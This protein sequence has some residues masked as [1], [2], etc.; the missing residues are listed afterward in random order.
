[1]WFL[2][3][4]RAR[5]LRVR[6]LKGLPPTVPVRF[7]MG[8]LRAGGGDSNVPTHIRSSLLRTTPRLRTSRRIYRVEY[9]YATIRRRRKGIT[10]FRIHLLTDLSTRYSTSSDAF[11]RTELRT[12][13]S[14]AASLRFIHNTYPYAPRNPPF[15]SLAIH[16]QQS[17]HPDAD[18]LLS[19][20]NHPASCGC[21]TIPA[22]RIPYPG[23]DP[24]ILLCFLLLP[25]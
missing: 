11:E 20:L 12:S 7:R 4:V 23:R 13:T 21:N 2:E 25:P 14:F 6:D 22:Y 15:S 8:T 24:K 18:K 9:F 1:M 5:A 19:A 16:L 3:Y 17:L 10:A